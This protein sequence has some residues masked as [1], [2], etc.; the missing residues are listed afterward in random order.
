MKNLRSRFFYRDEPVGGAKTIARIS[1]APVYA[2]GREQGALKRQRRAGHAQC[3]AGNVVS[4]TNM[5]A[6]HAGGSHL[7]GR[8]AHAHFL[9]QGIQFDSR[10]QT[11]CSKTYPNTALTPPYFR[12]QPLGDRPEWETRVIQCKREKEMGQAPVVSRTDKRGQKAHSVLFIPSGDCRGMFC[13]DGTNSADRCGSRL[14]VRGI[15]G[16]KMRPVAARAYFP[17]WVQAGFRAPKLA[18]HSHQEKGA[19]NPWVLYGAF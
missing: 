8:V 12:S 9:S 3:G 7:T 10:I 16:D 17:P 5:A 2:E 11:G 19:V 15:A 4:R 14:R 18:A 6:R 13:A 1:V